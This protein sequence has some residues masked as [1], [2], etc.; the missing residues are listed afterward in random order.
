MRITHVRVSQ[1]EGILEH[2]SPFWDDAEDST[3]PLPVGPGRY[4]IAAVFVAIET[5]E[6]VTGLGGPIDDERGR[7]IA[8]R[9][10]PL[11]VGAD[12]CADEQIWERL[13]RAGSHKRDR[14]TM[15]A[16]SIL[17]CALW[18]LKAKW[19]QVPVYRLL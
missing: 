13:Y 16:I 5:D 9:F 18:D 14:T 11:L 8:Q 2:P 7:L 4:Q 3:Y 6:G 15:G 19:L 1:L 10:A 17:D 12:P